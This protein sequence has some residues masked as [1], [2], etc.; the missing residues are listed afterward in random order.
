M[1]I[2]QIKIIE[3]DQELNQACSIGDKENKIIQDTKK[4]NSFEKKS[5]TVSVKEV[6]DSNAAEM[7]DVTVS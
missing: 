5:V 1:N 6:I 7:N 2:E 4:E 3:R